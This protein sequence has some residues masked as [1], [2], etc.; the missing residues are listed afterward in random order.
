MGLG[1]ILLAGRIR[2][3]LLFTFAV[4]FGNSHIQNQQAHHKKRSFHDEYVA[5]LD[6]F[7]VPY[8]QRYVFKSI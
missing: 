1:K 5:L 8:D 6:K 4:R 2:G 7:D 3:F